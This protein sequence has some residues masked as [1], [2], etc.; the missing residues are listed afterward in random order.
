MQAYYIHTFKPPFS[1]IIV[2][3]K[4]IIS[5]IPHPLISCATPWSNDTA[6]SSLVYPSAPVEEKQERWVGSSVAD[7]VEDTG[8]T[9]TS[10]LT[11]SIL[12]TLHPNHPGMLPPD[13]PT[14]TINTT[15]QEVLEL[16]LAGRSMDRCSVEG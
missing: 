15:L 4:N 9:L 10:S 3:K 1:F 13:T 7:D 12:S 11:T 14:R 8:T 16:W 2:G 5:L 6:L